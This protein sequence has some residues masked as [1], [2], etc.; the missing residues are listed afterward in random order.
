MYDCSNDNIVLMIQINASYFIKQ[1]PTLPYNIYR[2]IE[3]EKGNKELIVLKNLLLK[4]ALNY[5]EQR[6]GYK[7]MNTNNFFIFF[8]LMVT[9]F[10]CDKVK[11]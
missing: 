2:T 6:P 9:L 5:V 1:F 7:I 4:T 10:I 3:K 11:K 8:N